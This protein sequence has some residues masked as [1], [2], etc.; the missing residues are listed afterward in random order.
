M[1]RLKTAP[2]SSPVAHIK[3]ITLL[4]PIPQSIR[5]KELA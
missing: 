2:S 4:A 3:S 1:G 5:Y